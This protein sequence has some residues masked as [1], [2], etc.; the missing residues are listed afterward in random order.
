MPG[1]DVEK[2]VPSSSAVEKQEGDMEAGTPGS[3]KLYPIIRR[4]THGF[5]KF[6]ISH[7]M[8]PV[9]KGYF[10]GTSRS[11]LVHLD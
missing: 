2:S 5:F 7:R 9:L 6:I 10:T 3:P 8:I 4:K 1:E 11:G